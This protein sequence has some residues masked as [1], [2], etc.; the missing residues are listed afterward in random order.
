MSQVSVSG[1][2][3]QQIKRIADRTRSIIEL[4]TGT[5]FPIVQLL[6]LL[7]VPF[8]EEGPSQDGEPLLGFEV[9]PDE[10]LKNCYAEYRLTS[11]TLVV[12]E[13]VYDGACHGNGRDRFTLAHELG[14]SL[15]HRDAVNS[16]ARNEDKIPP[17]EDPEWQANTFA[18]MLLIPRN[19]ISGLT[20][21]DVAQ[22]YEVSRQAAEIAL[23]QT[24]RPNDASRSLM[25]SPRTK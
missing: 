24:R 5:A 20:V 14:H 3:R 12:R 22:R 17:Y 9:V 10:E 2:S 11:N 1:L 7:S 4:P 21:D 8:Q 16:F 18:S 13:S 19:E 6:E 15:L 23:R 25:Q